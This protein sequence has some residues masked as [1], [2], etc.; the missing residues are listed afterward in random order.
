ML[1]ATRRSRPPRFTSWLSLAVVGLV[2]ATTPTFLVIAAVAQEAPEPAT[3]K[4]QEPDSATKPPGVSEV[5]KAEPRDLRPDA[6]APA[7]LAG[8]APF[9]DLVTLANGYL[10]AIG[11]FESGTIELQ[12]AEEL[13]KKRAITD[14]EVARWQA[15]V[16]HAERRANL[17]RQMAEITRKAAQQETKSL[18]ADLNIQ[19]VLKQTGVRDNRSELLAAQRRLQQAE[20]RLEML[21]A[22]LSVSRTESQDGKDAAP[23][24]P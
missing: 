14:H 7:T 4:S 20:A 2:I 6:L 10:E 24:K 23:A 11:D 12:R 19:A 9:L 1:P 18:Q 3:A 5:P 22:I 21:E 13:L 8:S 17:F 16:M 15:A